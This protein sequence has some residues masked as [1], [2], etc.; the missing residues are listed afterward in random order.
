MNVLLSVLL[1]F[2]GL[3]ML[4]KGADI[5]V[6]AGSN[7]GRIFKISEI[8]IGLTF[9]CVGTGLPEL[10]LSI[11]GSLNGNSDFVVGNIVGTNIFNMCCILGMICIMNPLKL[12]RQT[13]RKDMNMSL[14]SS[15]ILFILLIDTFGT[16]LTDNII[17]RT[18]GIILLLFFAVFMYYTLYEFGEYLRDRREKKYRERLEKKARG[19]EVPEEKHEARVL[20][21][22]DVKAILKNFLIGII[23]ATMVY[24][25][26]EIVVSS[27]TDIAHH[28]NVSETFISIAIIAVGTSLPE[29]TT[30]IAAIKK[31][32]INIAIGNLIGSN[33][34]NTLFVIGC[35][36]LVNPIKI[37]EVSLLIDCGVFILVCL[38]MVLFTK[39]KPEIT[40]AEGLT[41]ISIYIV[42]IAYVIFRR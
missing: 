39:K 30:S 11:T 12:L 32:R 28:F 2:V 29:I 14:L 33:M 7:I 1:M 17:S 27:A 9:V 37:S 18:D 19:E 42:Y 35:A 4:V 8:L 38:V 22:K 21:M 10:L 3:V 34:F 16:N 20:T 13:V 41:L 31:N 6:D 25:G 36:A 40:R 24:F 23:G 5:F 26:A 15:V